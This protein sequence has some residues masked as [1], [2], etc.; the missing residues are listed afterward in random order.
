MANNYLAWM[1]HLDIPD[2]PDKLI[3]SVDLIHH[4]MATRW[5]GFAELS[6]NVQ[7][8]ET[9]RDRVYN[10]FAGDIVFAVEHLVREMDDDI[11]KRFSEYLQNNQEINEAS[12]TRMAE[13]FRHEFSANGDL[14]LRSIMRYFVALGL[15]AGHYYTRGMFQARTLASNLIQVA[16]PP[17][18][19]ENSDYWDALNAASRLILG[20]EEEVRPADPPNLNAAEYQEHPSPRNIPDEPLKNN[21]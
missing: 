8:L 17:E 21:P 7:N 5:P 2:N 1:R 15:L 12:F 6:R 3:F 4:V 18:R 20:Y 14:N 19:F 10:A 16:L 11:E 9:F 13:D